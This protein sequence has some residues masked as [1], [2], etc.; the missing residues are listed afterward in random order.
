MYKFSE[1]LTMFLASGTLKNLL[2]LNMAA[3]YL[4]M[5][6]SRKSIESCNKVSYIAF[7]TFHG[8]PF[9]FFS[10]LSSKAWR[11]FLVDPIQVLD[12]NPANIKA[13]YRRGMAYMSAGDFEEAGTDFKAV[14]PCNPLDTQSPY[15]I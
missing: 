14:S 2:N 11:C 3:C 13:L 4:K 15:V 5:G 10:Q 6:E 1:A 9:F 7:Y 8:V 12:A